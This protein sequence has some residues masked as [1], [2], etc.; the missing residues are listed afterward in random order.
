MH[1]GWTSRRRRVRLRIAGVGGPTSGI[2]SCSMVTTAGHC[3]G[4]ACMQRRLED[5]ALTMRGEQCA[6]R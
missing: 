2:V 6:G 5:A 3:M 4:L 1:F